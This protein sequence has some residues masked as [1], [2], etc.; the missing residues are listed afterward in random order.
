MPQLTN[1]SLYCPVNRSPTSAAVDDEP[2]GLA[3]AGQLTR[4][5]TARAGRRGRH[6]HHPRHRHDGRDVAYFLSLASSTVTSP[7]CSLDPMPGNPP[8]PSVPTARS[9]FTTASPS[10]PIPSPVVA[11]RWWCSTTP[12]ITAHEAQKM[13]TTRMDTF[14]SP[15]PRHRRDDEHGQGVLLFDGACTRQT[16]RTANF[17]WA[18]SKGVSL[19]CL[20][21]D[22]VYSYANLG[23]EVIDA[24][25]TQG[26]K[27]SMCST[28]CG[29]RQ[30]DGRRAGYA[31]EQAAQE[32]R[33]GGALLAHRQRRGGPP[34]SKS[35]DDKLGFIAGMELKRTEGPH[36]FD[37]GP[38]ANQ[39]SQEAPRVFCP[40]Y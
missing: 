32:G 31:L 38:H 35:N 23:G 7:S 40:Q 21:V 18:R 16:G 19:T 20:R 13:H 37:A 3:Q 28:K 9:I 25:V 29:R 2:R 4:Q 33:G 1:V 24:M 30:Y 5:R 17:P 15:N 27:G 12:F 14:Q 39:R 36:S 8:R 10:P 26:V 34:T 22:I 11:G 6:R